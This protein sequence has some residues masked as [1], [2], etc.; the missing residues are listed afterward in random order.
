MKKPVILSVIVFLA[1]F[2]SSCIT[3]LSFPMNGVLKNQMDDFTH[4]KTV[5][6][7][8]NIKAQ[9]R[10]S[11]VHYI[12]LF[13]NNDGF[14]TKL[15][16]T[17]LKS[18]SAFY[19]EKKLYV[20]ADS[21]IIILPFKEV[22]NAQFISTHTSESIVSDSTSTT[23]TSTTQDILNHEMR[24]IY[25]IDEKLKLAILNSSDLTFRIYSGGKPS[26]FKLINIKDLKFVLRD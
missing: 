23:K 21:N 1:F 17:L 10:R 16:L 5:S 20:K 15:Y 22:E 9:E 13:I 8:V 6:Y 11:P 24:L 25:D 26:S 14:K 2:V 4:K 3:T 12:R 19:P 18:P 7:E